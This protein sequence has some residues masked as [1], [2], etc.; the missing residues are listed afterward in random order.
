MQSPFLNLAR[1]IILTFLIACAGCSDDSSGTPSPDSSVAPDTGAKPDAGQS[2]LVQAW[3]S[4][5]TLAQPESVTYDS[6]RGV[7]YVTSV[8][9]DAATKNGK[10]YITQMSLDGKIIKLQWIS[11]LNAPKGVSVSGDKLYTAD[12]DE[13][14]E[15]DVAKAAVLKRH[16]ATGAVMLND[17]TITPIGS[18]FVSDMGGNA[19]FRLIN[20]QVEQW[21][22]DTKLEVP[23]GVYM[24]PGKLFVASWGVITDPKTYATKVPGHIKMIDLG[25]KQISSLMGGKPLGNLDGICSDGNNNFFVTDHMKGQ[26]LWVEHSGKVTTLVTL[27]NTGTADLTYV[28]D[29]K[30]IV[31]PLM[32]KNQVV[33][34]Q[35]K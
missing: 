27:P 9:G 15:V 35:Y 32:Y 12:I 31:V 17:V 24:I 22:K 25:T 18:V 28:P 20:G 23:N 2:T 6:K 5:A 14:V 19:I 13:L 33:A 8:N 3:T 21:L 11:G 1:S 29:K 7:L 30:L 16:K 26:V 34:Y 4:P 10:G